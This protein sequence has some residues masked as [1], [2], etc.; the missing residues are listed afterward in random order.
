MNRPDVLRDIANAIG[1]LTDLGGFTYT[2]HLPPHP[3]ACAI[4]V[5][6]PLGLA[7]DELVLPI[8]TLGRRLDT[9]RSW[10]LYNEEEI[11]N[12]NP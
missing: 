10:V 11:R 12:T 1:M 6:G 7:T 2:I 8:E 3:A 4:K 9:A 5:R